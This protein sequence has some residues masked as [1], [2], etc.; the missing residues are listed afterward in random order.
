MTS[1]YS[2]Q[3]RAF[4][5]RLARDEG[6]DAAHARRL[7]IDDGQDFTARTKALNAA[8]NAE[9]ARRGLL[10]AMFATPSTTTTVN[11]KPTA[12]GLAAIR[13]AQARKG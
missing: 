2:P 5:R 8:A 12:A 1:K 4:M 10:P 9:R 13:R 7:L 6:A 11:T 3:Q